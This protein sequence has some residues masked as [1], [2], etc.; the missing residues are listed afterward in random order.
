MTLSQERRRFC[1]CVAARG[2]N[3]RLDALLDALAAQDLEGVIPVVIVI[4]SMHDDNLLAIDGASARHAG[5]LVVR[6]EE[7]RQ[8]SP[9][10]RSGQTLWR[11]LSLGISELGFDANGVLI[12]ASAQG[13]PPRHWLRTQLEALKPDVE[14][15]AGALV[16]DPQLPLTP[17]V[18]RLL[19][20]L[21]R[22]WRRVQ[23]LEDCI[24]PLPWDPPPRHYDRTMASLAITVGRY[25]HAGGMTQAG[26]G[27]TGGLIER[28]LAS[29][30]R[31][32]RPDEVWTRVPPRLMVRARSATEG[33]PRDLWPG[34]GGW[35]MPQVA[36]LAQWARRI[37]WRRHRRLMASDA[38]L[39][40]DEVDL[41][42]LAVD[43]FLDAA[44][45]APDP[46]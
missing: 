30:G 28:A 13:R 14:I 43:C 37:E 11:A 10:W 7:L 34:P 23:A 38:Q 15:V 27:P 24:D 46:D 45:T 40:R 22:Y 36:S 31:M 44:V 9:I 3:D 32:V 19:V 29:G 16:S 39:A 18:T 41:P 1:V 6:V 35:S 20:L 25:L 4:R 17:D 2:E 26:V 5:R 8:A 33:V 42:P 21:D 12:C